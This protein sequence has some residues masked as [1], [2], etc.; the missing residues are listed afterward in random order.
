LLRLHALALHLKNPLATAF[1]SSSP[2]PPIL[3]EFSG[4][5]SRR[6]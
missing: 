6:P 3:D 5:R 2:L 1:T 4:F